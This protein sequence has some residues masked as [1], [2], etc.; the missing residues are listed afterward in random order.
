MLITPQLAKQSQLRVPV[1]PTLDTCFPIPATSA[2]IREIIFERVPFWT[3]DEV[4]G[5]PFEHG[6]F[7]APFTDIR[8]ATFYKVI[9]T[10]RCPMCKTKF[11][12]ADTDDLRHP[13]ME[14]LAP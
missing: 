5:I 4:K 6:P 9:S 11:I 1:Y 13:C 12:V 3:C 14:S 7:I 8:R 2:A 10:W